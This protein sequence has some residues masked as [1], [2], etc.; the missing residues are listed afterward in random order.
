MLRA[1][2]GGV[3]DRFL[4]PEL[5]RLVGGLL[6]LLDG[7]EDHQRAVAQPAIEIAV[8]RL[9]VD[10]EMMRLAV[11]DH[12]DARLVVAIDTHQMGAPARL[13]VETEAPLRHAP[14]RGG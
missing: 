12:L 8:H 7:V 14:P 6:R 11:A 10:V 4:R 9:L 1:D 5:V 2:F 13:T 3:H